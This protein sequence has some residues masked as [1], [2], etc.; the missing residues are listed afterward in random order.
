[1][2]T[3]FAQVLQMSQERRLDMRMA[4]YILAIDRVNQATLIRGIYP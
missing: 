2:T 4:A 3:A 1:M